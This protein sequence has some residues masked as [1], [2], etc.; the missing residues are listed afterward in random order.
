[1]QRLVRRIDQDKD[2][3]HERTLKNWDVDGSD[4]YFRR[5]SAVLFS[6]LNC[7]IIKGVQIYPLSVKYPVVSEVIARGESLP[8]DMLKI[9]ESS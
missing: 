5:I 3:Q 7:L 4:C 6:I 8:K 1:M 2:M 9:F